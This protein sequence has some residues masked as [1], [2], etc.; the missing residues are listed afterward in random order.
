MLWKNGENLLEGDAGVALGQAIAR[1]AWIGKPG[2]VF[3][4]HSTIRRSSDTMK[5]AK[6]E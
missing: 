5:A 6:E 1:F 2:L 4:A 3:F